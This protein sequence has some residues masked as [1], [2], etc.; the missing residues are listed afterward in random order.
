M[1][2]LINEF[3]ERISGLNQDPEETQETAKTGS[4]PV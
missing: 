2:F 3:L 4:F 1:V